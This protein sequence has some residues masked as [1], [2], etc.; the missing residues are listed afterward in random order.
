MNH[1][2]S[3][4]SFS[5]L[6]TSLL[7]LVPG[8]LTAQ[9]LSEE[10]HDRVEEAETV[11]EKERG[12][13]FLND[14]NIRIGSRSDFAEK[15]KKELLTYFGLSVEE[16]GAFLKL[17]HLLPPE[18]HLS[19]AVSLFALQTVAAYY[20]EGEVVILE[21]RNPSKRL[22]VHELTHALD[23]DRFQFMRHY[24]ERSGNFDQIMA[25]T[26]VVEGSAESVESRFSGTFLKDREQHRKQA[27]SRW[28]RSSS[29]LPRMFEQTF[30]FS[31]RKGH[32]FVETI[33][34]SDKKDWNDL[35]LDPPVSTRQIL[36]P[37]S[38]LWGTEPVTFDIDPLERAVYEQEGLR[39][40]DTR[41]GQL[42]LFNMILSH[43]SSPGEKAE[44]IRSLT[45]GWRGDRMVVFDRE[46]TRE[47]DHERMFAVWLLTFDS[48]ETRKRVGT[49]LK[50]VLKGGLAG[51]VPDRS[52]D[53][54]SFQE[55]SGGEF[56]STSGGDRL[57][58]VRGAGS[59]LAVFFHIPA[60]VLEAVSDALPKIQKETTRTTSFGTGQ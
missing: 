9:E 2:V 45:D 20:S 22:L 55:R 7:V 42:G 17:I 52:G 58:G 11:V 39:F 10:I 18:L 54:F 43:V 35:F 60:P 8:L 40:F 25:L 27:M 16:L 51:K 47:R 14:Y 34:A 36:Q 59:D 44:K 24:R 3:R 28:V 13:S 32:V 53:D 12:L 6:I 46:E 26:A 5:G 57:H 56:L 21:N 30:Q 50:Q 33:R 15:Q 23:D 37:E 48:P 41:L 38:Y 49:R 19:D 1:F 29:P 4:I 31:Y